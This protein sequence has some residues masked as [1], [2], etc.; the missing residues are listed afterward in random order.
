MSVGIVPK[1]PVGTTP[2][3]IFMQAVW[4]KL[5]GGQSRVQDVSGQRV[6]RTTQGTVTIPNARPRAGGAVNED[7][8][9]G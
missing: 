7:C 4:D 2:E 1:R 8:P 3:A 6:N 9:Y 5:W